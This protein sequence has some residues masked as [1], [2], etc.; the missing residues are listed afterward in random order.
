[1]TV[2]GFD[3]LMDVYQP[4]GIGPWPVVVAFHGLDSHGKDDEDTIR[5][6]EAAATEGMLVFA[7]SWIVWNPGPFPFTIDI[8]EGW[9]SAANCAVA[10]AQQ[11]AAEYDGDPENTALYGF[12]AGAGAALLAAVEPSGDPLPGCATDAPPTPARGAV[13]GD[14]EYFLHSDGFDEAFQS[15]P[16]AMQVEVARLTDETY[17][18]PD[19]STRFFLWVA[20]EGT[21]PRAI[22]DASDETGWLAQRDPDGSIR[23][24]LVRLDQLD[25]GTISF[26][27]A[28]ELLELRLSEAGI[29]VTLDEYPGGH[30]TSNKV[31]ELISYLKAAASP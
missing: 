9:K 30:T 24:D 8:F 10:S 12:S 15:D 28:G 21:S 31:P 7:P 20:A 23:S 16:A 18:P 25:D 3:L 11:R 14:G 17:W 1:M 26:I 4:A 29:D 22:D 13:L 27:D 5:V 6:A 19:L 2:N